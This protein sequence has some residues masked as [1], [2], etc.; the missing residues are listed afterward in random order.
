MRGGDG[1]RKLQVCAGVWGV[2]VSSRNA[3][4]VGARVCARRMAKH[5]V[6][7]IRNSYRGKAKMEKEQRGQA[8]LRGR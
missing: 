8:T 4:I 1:T 3:G 7:R 6:E 2:T 5:G